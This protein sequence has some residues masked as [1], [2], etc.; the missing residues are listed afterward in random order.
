MFH[1]LPFFSFYIAY[2][3][4]YH[5]ILNLRKMND[6]GPVAHK[7]KIKRK[8]PKSNASQKNQT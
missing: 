7:K 1:N 3:Y 5:T 2:Y 6:Q 4:L 8:S